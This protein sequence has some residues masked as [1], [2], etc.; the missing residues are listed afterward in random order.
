MSSF[1]DVFVGISQKYFEHLFQKKTF[2][3]MF[4]ISLKNTSGWVSACNEATLKKIFSGSKPSSKLTLKTKWYHSC[5]CSDD[6]QVVNNWRS[7]ILIN[8]LKK[9]QTLNSNHLPLQEMY[10][11]ITILEW[12][13]SSRHIC[14]TEIVEEKHLKL[15]K[16]LNQIWGPLTTLL[17]VFYIALVSFGRQ[18][19]CQLAYKS[20]LCVSDPDCRLTSK[21]RYLQNSKLHSNP[22]YGPNYCSQT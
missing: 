21:I 15:S 3:W 19:Q 10:V 1:T 5:S 11:T 4:H 22:R 20:W 18:L 13:V 8:I 16:Y 12:V 7:V 17:L 9:S 2:R 6:S 14:F